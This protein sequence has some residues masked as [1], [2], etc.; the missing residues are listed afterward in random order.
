L[1]EYG[2][3]TIELPINSKEK[4]IMS[5][6]RNHQLMRIG[7]LFG[8]AAGILGAVNAVTSAALV[9]KM[10]EEIISYLGILG[11]AALAL[12]A[13]GL[14]AHLT[15]RPITGLWVGLLVALLAALIATATRVGYSVAYYNIVRNDPSEMRSWIH[16]GSASFV[17]YLIADRIGG[18]INTTV[19]FG[20]VC[21]IGGLAGAWISQRRNV[22]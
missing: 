17:D 20:I 2:C 1:G 18:F 8:L 6:Y 5:T 22:A 16:R 7:L 3:S 19:L 13:G 14:A 4:M 12:V 9:G 11:I 10:G 21:G 15:K